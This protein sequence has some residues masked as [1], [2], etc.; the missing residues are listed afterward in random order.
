MMEILRFLTYIL[1]IVSLFTCLISV[2]ITATA[3]IESRF[4]ERNLSVAVKM[5]LTGFLIVMVFL[6][7]Y[8]LIK[9]AFRFIGD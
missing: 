8:F 3:M 4:W 2:G 5:L 9:L 1:V 6:S 7:P